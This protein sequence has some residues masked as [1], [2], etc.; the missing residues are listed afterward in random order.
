M[1][2]VIGKTIP[3]IDASGP[4]ALEGIGRCQ[5]RDGHSAAATASLRQALVIYEQ[6]DSPQIERLRKLIREIGPDP[7]EDEGF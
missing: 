2:V 1:A 5:L 4:R 6:I 3:G 7:Q